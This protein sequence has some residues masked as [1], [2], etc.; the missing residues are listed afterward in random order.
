MATL[1]PQ[2]I[3]RIVEVAELNT[4]SELWNTLSKEAASQLGLRLEK[5]G[6]A[7]ALIMSKVDIGEF[8]RVIG[9]GIADKAT[10][11][12]IDRIVALYAPAGNTYVVHVDPAAQPADLPTWLER[13][14]FRRSPN[15]IW[16]YRNAGEPPNI[17][18]DLRIGC[19]GPEDAIAFADVGL[20]AFDMPAELQPWAASLVGR[21]NWRNYLAFDGDQPVAIA[22][23]F[24]QDGVGWLGNGATLPS[25][26]RRGAQGALMAQRI[27]DGIS[28][29]CKWFVSET[30]EDTV[31]DPNPSYR[32]M[33]R[34]G[35]KPAFV[36]ANYVV[37]KNYLSDT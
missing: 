23:L 24:V 8:N 20:A 10:E 11:T 30:A 25:H 18:T 5:L 34:T 14:G 36:R 1:T 13:R 35:F 31:N 32:N 22:S 29:H 4:C 21:P 33:L 2:E 27:R 26:R 9:L 16:V 37:E 12:D 28:M 6:S 17:T 19:I 7:T 15:S 3:S